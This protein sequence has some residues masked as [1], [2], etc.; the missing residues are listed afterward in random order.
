M[1]NRRT[2]ETNALG[3]LSLFGYDGMGRLLSVTNGMGS[4]TATNWATY[5]YDEAGNLTNQV[6]AL[7]HTNKYE[8]DSMGRRTKHTLPGSQVETFGY[9]AVG[10]LVSYT[11]FNGLILT[12]QYDVMNRLWKKWNGSTLLET[13]TYDK[14]GQL[15]NRLDTSGTYLWVFDSRGRV[16]TNS[17]PFGS[18]YPNVA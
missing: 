5:A 2:A 18:L 9:D 11:N 3:V 12:N 6:D 14:V 8:F 17:T 15:T 4:G 10:N 13:Y 16:T 1:A 7:S